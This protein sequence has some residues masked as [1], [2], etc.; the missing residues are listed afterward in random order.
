GDDPTDR[1]RYQTV[2]AASPGSVAAPTAGLHF[3]GAV[4]ER[5]RARGIEAVDVTLH[6][7]PGTFRPIKA[8]T[9]EAHDLHAEWAAIA[10]DVADRLNRARASGGRV[11]AVG[12]TAA[13]V[14]ETCVD[15]SGTFRPFAGPTRIYLRPGVPVRGVD[16][17]VTNF[18][19]PRSSL[20]MLVSALAGVGLIRAAYAEA[21]GRRYR[22]YSYGDAMII[23]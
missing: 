7:G 19:L 14:L 22:F 12:T 1:E 2:Y 17:L 10:P 3:T 6:V 20:L 5:L 21:V 23:L 13:R 8:D 15:P 4:F 11:V 9:I 16:A 18:H